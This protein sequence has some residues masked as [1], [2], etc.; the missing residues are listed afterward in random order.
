M[1]G[2]CRVRPCGG[3]ILVRR[4]DVGDVGE[5][6]AVEGVHD[7]RRVQRDGERQAT[8]AGNSSQREAPSGSVRKV[9][10]VVLGSR[11]RLSSVDLHG[12]SRR[13]EDD[14]GSSFS[15]N[16]ES[17]G[18]SVN[19]VFLEFGKNLEIRCRSSLFFGRKIPIVSS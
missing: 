2:E 1:R 4:G 18:I 10:D 11:D 13:V 6:E 5:R 12:S 9:D 16:P 7:E 15:V 14:G 8:K 3:H 17:S 19:P